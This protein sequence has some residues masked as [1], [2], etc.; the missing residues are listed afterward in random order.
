MR[1]AYLINQYPTVSHTFI[2]RE[3]LALERQGFEIMRISI[4]GWEKDLLDHADLAERGKTRY[5]LQSGWLAIGGAVLFAA[6]SHPVHFGRAFALAVRMGWKAD[7]PLPYHLIYFAEA[8]LIERWLAKFNVEHVHAHF[9]TN[10]AEVAMLVH[11]LG[12][13]PFSFTAHGPEEFDKPHSLG[14]AE[15]IRRASFVVAVSSF[16]RSQLFRLIEHKHWGKIQVVRCGLDPAYSESAATCVET[17]NF[18]CVGRLCEQ[19]GQLLLIEAA[20]RL[21]EIGVDFALTIAGDGELRSEVEAL[22]QQYKLGSNVRV[23]G[24]ISNEEVRKQLLAARALV[25]PSFAEGLPVVIMEALALRRPVVSTFVAG[26][27]ELVQDGEHGWLVPPGDIDALVVAIKRCLETPSD[28]LQGMGDAAFERVALL[29]NVHTET[30]RLASLIINRQ[31]IEAG[32][33]L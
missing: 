23:T 9:G 6:I 32:A 12:G 14:L 22:I 27:P 20:R 31:H 18:V 8:C 16:G 33:S 26:I 1:I 3:I 15:K 17:R 13:P 5:V 10:S 28:R 4:R 7:R 19:K 30:A 29:H 25:L 24:W 2:R 21:F 11:A